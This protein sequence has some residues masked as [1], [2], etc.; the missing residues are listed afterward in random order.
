[1]KISTIAASEIDKYVANSNVIIVDVRDEREY[2]NRHIK[3]AI[4]VPLAQIDNRDFNS[5]M[6]IIVYCERGAKSIIAA[7][8]LLQKGYNVKTVVG[9]LSAYRGRFLS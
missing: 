3:G 1:M 2:R 9:G 7:S 5:E 6:K 8:K 4:N